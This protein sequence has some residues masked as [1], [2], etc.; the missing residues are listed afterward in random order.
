MSKGDNK[1]EWITACAKHRSH[2]VPLEI[3]SYN[4]GTRS[5]LDHVVHLY[6]HQTLWHNAL[7]VS[8]Y[9]VLDLCSTCQS[10]GALSVT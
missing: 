1:P 6:D 5:D 4:G 8:S 7:Y 9:E 3:I 2:T 10:V